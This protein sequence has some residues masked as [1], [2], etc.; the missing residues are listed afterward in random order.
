MGNCNSGMS[1]EEKNLMKRD[2]KIQVVL[3][4][5]RFQMQDNFRIL[6]LGAGESGKSTLFKQMRILQDGQFSDDEIEKN[7][8]SIFNN[9]ISQMK[10]LVEESRKLK[11]NISNQ[12]AANGIDKLE[13]TDSVMNEE[14][15]K[16]IK[17]LWEDEGIKE[18]FEQRHLQFQLNDSA[19][20]FFDNI[21]RIGKNG[22]TPNSEDILQC[23]IRTDQIIESR[24][25]INNLTFTMIDVGGQRTAR[26]KWIHYF[27]NVTSVIF[28]ASLAAYEQKLREDETVNRMH[29]ALSLFHEICSSV[30][31]SGSSMILF[32]NKKDLFKKQI[33]K[34]DLRSCFSDYDGQ[35]NNYNEAYRFIKNKFVQAS[36]LQGNRTRKLYVFRTCAVNTKNIDNVFRSVSDTI[37]RNL[38]KDIQLV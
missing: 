11:K 17:N 8:P 6:L 21:D 23:R 36:G 30:W 2:K 27:Y 29:E 20:Y 16:W 7:K 1:E 3:Q 35:P 4:K 26:R 12:E 13:Y 24:F 18:T 33:K 19:P 15:A 22:Y 14:I 31:F 32:L 10:I 34:T 38:V 25:R 37:M 9:C 28:C 5:E